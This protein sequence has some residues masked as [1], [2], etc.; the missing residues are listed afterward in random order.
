VSITRQVQRQYGLVKAAHPVD[1]DGKR[2]RGGGQTLARFV[3]YKLVKEKTVNKQS[4]AVVFQ[5]PAP[6]VPWLVP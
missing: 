2:G 4:E 5:V 6:P 1:K 3:A